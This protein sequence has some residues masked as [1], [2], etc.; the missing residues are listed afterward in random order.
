MCEICG[1]GIGHNPRCPN[2]RQPEAPKCPKCGRGTDKYAYDDDGEFIC[3]ENCIRWVDAW[4]VT[5]YGK[6]I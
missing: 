6:A 2:A 3:C 4:E 1:A 5:E